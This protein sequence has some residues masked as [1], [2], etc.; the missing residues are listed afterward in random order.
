MLYT[1][2]YDDYHGHQ[3][4]DMFGAINDEEAK[5]KANDIV[6]GIGYGSD[7]LYC[8]SETPHRKVNW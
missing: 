6:C 4:S 5:K 8:I 7:T 3:H 2:Y 1:V